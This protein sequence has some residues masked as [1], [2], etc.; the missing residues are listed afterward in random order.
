MWLN[1]VGYLWTGS[2]L[3]AVMVGIIAFN[4][5][6]MDRSVL[7][8]L[9]P[10]LWLGGGAIAAIVLT[11]VSSSLGASRRVQMTLLTLVVVL[12]AAFLVWGSVSVSRRL[13]TAYR[14]G[15]TQGA[16]PQV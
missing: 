9:T 11:E 15:R 4:I 1:S 5:W 16:R 14:L 10:I 13:W 7:R 3:I 6:R 8:Q 12:S 2:C